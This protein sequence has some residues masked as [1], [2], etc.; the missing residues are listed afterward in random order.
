MKERTLTEKNIAEFSAYLRREEK[1][2]NTIEKY[3]RDA[4]ALLD[5]LNGRVVTKEIVIVY[6]YVI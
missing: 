5:F 2:K 6:S 3:I 1:S 4:R